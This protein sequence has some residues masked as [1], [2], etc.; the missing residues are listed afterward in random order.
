VAPATM[1]RW[2]SSSCGSCASC[3]APGF[4][5][6]LGMKPSTPR[7]SPMA[8]GAP[9]RERTGRTVLAARRLRG[10]ATAPRVLGRQGGSGHP[11]ARG[12][13]GLLRVATGFSS[14]VNRAES[15]LV[16]PSLSCIG[17]V[18]ISAVQGA[19]VA[20]RAGS[21]RSTRWSS[22]ASRFPRFGATT[23]LSLARRRHRRSRRMTWGQMLRL[24]HLHLRR[25]AR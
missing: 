6:G 12:R 16:T 17:G 25:D 4:Q 13:A 11:V 2:R 14:A 22:S 7:S 3:L 24:G 15:V 19:R 8:R 9:D 23:R 18:G 10:T 1:S 21:S 20:G 5:C